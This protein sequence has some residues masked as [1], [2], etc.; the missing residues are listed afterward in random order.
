MFFKITS[1]A[2]KFHQETTPFSFHKTTEWNITRG[3]FRK[4]NKFFFSIVELENSK[5]NIFN[6]QRDLAAD[7]LEVNNPSRV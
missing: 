1:I 5:E 4:Q 3:L 2:V 7:H 6:G